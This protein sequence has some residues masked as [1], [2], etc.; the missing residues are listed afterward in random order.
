MKFRGHR[1]PYDRSDFLS[2]LSARAKTKK[3]HLKPS[4]NYNI[5]KTINMSQDV[6]HSYG[7]Q[8]FIISVVIISVV[9]ISVVTISVVIISV[10]IFSVVIF[11]AVIFSAVIFFVVIFS[12]VIC[13]VVTISVV[14]TRN[15][16]TQGLIFLPRSQTQSK[17]TQVYACVKH[18]SC[19]CFF[20]KFIKQ[21]HL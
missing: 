14:H 9:I 19:L 2:L 16:T 3:P 12:V 8:R 18:T 6:N 5:N 11:S 13:Y 10:V 20:A 17:R 1:G 4:Y 7:N 15:H 21:S